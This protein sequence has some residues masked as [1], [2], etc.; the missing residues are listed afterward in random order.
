M[1]GNNLGSNLSLGKVLSGIS[2]TLNIV[3]QA[4]PIYNQL[5]PIVSNASNSLSVF[6]EMNNFNKKSIYKKEK[7]K[8]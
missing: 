7:K 2:K 1:Y 8:P 3:N 5:K 6:K 4:I